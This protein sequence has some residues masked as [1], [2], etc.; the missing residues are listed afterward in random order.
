M[1]RSAQMVLE[2]STSRR[3]SAAAMRAAMS[4]ERYLSL[5]SPPMLQ[6]GGPER[7]SFLSISSQG[8]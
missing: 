4:G 6:Q 8:R 5:S 2:R 3:L 1:A 7:P